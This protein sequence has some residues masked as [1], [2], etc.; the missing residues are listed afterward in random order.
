[1]KIVTERVLL[2]AFTLAIS[3]FSEAINNNK[4][5]LWRKDNYSTKAGLSETVYYHRA[6]SVQ[7][8]G[9]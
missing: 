8:S 6:L 5:S 4:I 9:Q 3:L 1:M 2:F 7:D